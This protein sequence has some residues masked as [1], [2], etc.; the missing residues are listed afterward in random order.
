MASSRTQ[1]EIRQRAPLWLGMLL[2][3]NLVV[4]AVD[5]RDNLAAQRLLRGWTQAIASPFQGATSRVSG[6]GADLIR[7]I[8]NFRGAA[9][10]NEQLKQRLAKTELELRNAHQAESENER[11]KGLLNLKERTGYDQIAARVIARDAS[12]WFNTITINCGTSSGVAL[13]MPVVTAGGIVGRVIVVSPV[14]SQVMLITDEKAAAGAVV[15]RLGESGALGSVRGLG[16]TGL[17]EMRYVSGLQ[18]VDVGDYIL[19]TGQDG[20]YPAGLNVGEVVELKRGTATQPHHIYV[21]PSS[22]LDQLEEVAVLLYR[23]L[24][25]PAPEQALPNVDKTK[26]ISDK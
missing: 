18:K 20:I 8:V 2:F 25:R 12:V 3:A 1:R 24:Q 5:A 7:Q 6:A 11:L 14:T 23:P 4:M 17:L 9:Y 26:V 13:N 16:N 21:K 22:P 15:G 10:E 19:T